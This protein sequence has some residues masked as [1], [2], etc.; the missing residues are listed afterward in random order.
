MNQPPFSKGC[1]FERKG[2]KRQLL[3][4]HWNSAEH[5]T[6]AKMD[7]VTC[8]AT[9]QNLNEEGTTETTQLRKTLHILADYCKSEFHVDTVV[10]EGGI[11]C[12]LPFLKLPNEGSARSADDQQVSGNGED[13]AAKDAC[14]IL[15][16]LAVRGEYQPIIADSGALDEL[17]N[18]VKMHNGVFGGLG[19]GGGG[20]KSP[21]KSGSVARRA[22]DAITNLAHENVYVKNLVRIKGGIPPL[23]ALLEAWDPKAQ[24]AAAGALRT[25]A[26]R[27]EENKQQIVQN[28]ALDLLIRMLSSEE[29]AVH[30]EAVGVIGN[31]VHSSANIKK[32]VLEAG[33]LQPVISLLQSSCGESQRE[34]ALLLGQFATADADYKA[35]IV[36]RGAVPPLISMLGNSDV[37]LKEMATFALGRLAQNGDNQAGIL[38]LGGLSPL[39]DLLESKNSNLQHNAAFAL[40]GLADSEDNVCT[41]IKEGGYSRLIKAELIVQASKDCVQKTVK[42]LE[43]KLQGRV[44]GQLLYQLRSQNKTVQQRIATAFARLVPAEDLKLVFYDHR[45]LEVLLEVIVSTNSDSEDAL[46][47]TKE[48]TSAVFDLAMKIKKTAPIESAP[49]QPART[50]YL[51]EQYV[52]NPTLADVTFIVDDQ[53]F[54]AHK[55]ALL[56]SS[57]AFR[58]MFDGGYKERDANTIEIP[59]IRYN[60]FELMMI[61]TYTGEVEVPTEVAQDLLRASDQ[62]LLEGLKHQCEETIKDII[63]TEN[64]SD[65]Y[66]LSESCMANQL[67]HHC[68][69]FVL[70]RS[71]EMILTYGLAKFLELVTKMV[72]QLRETLTNSLL[73]T[74]EISE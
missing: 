34:A 39:L 46:E 26:F 54:Y 63:S 12:L 8:I 9:L 40:Y 57:S 47:V 22:A 48:A 32:Q 35:K 1:K 4:L 41:I 43:E 55:I 10:K 7:V 38:H 53:K 33:A 61:Y 3:E 16:L 73:R 56:A 68:V 20:V 36:Q 27:N 45:G 24:R 2:F 14:F 37:Q 58:A 67:G 18:L 15:G 71:N 52:N 50:V 60:V 59:N 49:Q 6:T 51:G 66:L 28:G 65:I 42:R 13:E 5:L 44:L 21:N 30:Y 64:I 25:L 19:G 17:V 69:M 29:T 31:L 23:V 72:P 70:E 74:T 62:Y 11:S